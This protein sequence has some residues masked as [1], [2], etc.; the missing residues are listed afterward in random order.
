MLITTTARGTVTTTL[1]TVTLSRAL[2]TIAAWL[3][4]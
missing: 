1:I 4:S 2:R 3:I